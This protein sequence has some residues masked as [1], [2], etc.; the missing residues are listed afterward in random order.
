MTE[1]PSQT[2]PPE[3][4]TA[5]DEPHTF[6]GSLE[7]Q[8]RTFAWKVAGLDAEGLH[9]QV[10]VSALSLAKLLK[11]LAHMEDVNVTAGFAGDPLPSPWDTWDREADPDWVWRSAQEDSPEELVAL[12]R[13]AVTRSRAVVDRTLATGGMASV[14]SYQTSDGGPVSLRRFVADLIEE[15]ARHVGHA[16]II[17]ESVDGQ[18]G[19]DPPD[20]FPDL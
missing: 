8:R 16:D 5:G 9:A 19:E 11:H 13:T 10:G 6:L 4:A 3:P 7:R 14:G 15:Y 2:F 1:S 17:R 12:W 18:V 20:D